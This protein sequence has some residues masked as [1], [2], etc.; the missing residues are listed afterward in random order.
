MAH[1]KRKKCRYHPNGRHHQGSQTT[2]RVRLG[3][4]PVPKDWRRDGIPWQEIW[5]AWLKQYSAHPAHW[6]RTYH[7]RPHRMRTKRMERQILMGR[8]D[9]DDAAWPIPNRPYIYYW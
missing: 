1:Y 2:F 3:L 5:P 7:I 6:D 9:P 8:I 4:K